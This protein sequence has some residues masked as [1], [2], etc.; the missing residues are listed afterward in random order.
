M[1][2]NRLKFQISA[3]LFDNMAMRFRVVL[4]LSL[5]LQLL[6]FAHADEFKGVTYTKPSGWVDAEESG[7]KVLVPKNLK[8]GEL[9]VVLLTGAAPSDGKPWEKQFE[10]AI[11]GANDGAK[12]LKPGKTEKTAGQK[13]TI[14]T[15]SVELDHKDIGK[16]SRLYIQ[17]SNDK[18]RVFVTVLMNKES[19]V[20]T[21]GDA[22]AEFLASVAFK[23]APAT[24]NPPKPPATTTT[25]SKIPFGNTP[26]LYPGMPGWL[27]SGKGAPIPLPAI[28]GGKP[29]GVWYELTSP[30]FATL[31]VEMNVYLPDGRYAST[32]R[33]GG[34]MLLDYDA[35]RNAP[36]ATGTGVFSVSEGRMT[37]TSGNFKG[38]GAFSHGKNSEGVF[39][40]FGEHIYRPLMPVTAKTLSGRWKAVGVEYI[41][42]EDGTFSRRAL[43]TDGETAVGQRDTGTYVVD[44]YLIHLKPAN[45]RD[46]IEK[47]GMGSGKYLII[48][49]KTYV[50]G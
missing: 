39:F 5:L 1:C 7:A 21:Y 48:G 26:S 3:D 50:R 36:G 44:G 30:A 47:T 24:A 42:H 8:E 4:A 31:N 9:F 37:F 33:F 11:S 43:H 28:V 14:L 49:S 23:A 12:I 38:N 41:F 20:D 13:L 32:P 29:Q 6:G 25:A 22:F 2:L 40:K 16:H 19:L 17:I 45:A 34:P 35:Q 10:D 15:Q 27:P 18:Q 46:W